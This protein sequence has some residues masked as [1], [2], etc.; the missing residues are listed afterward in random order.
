M[1][2]LLSVL[3]TSQRLTDIACRFR[4]TTWQATVSFALFGELHR[5]K[6]DFIRLNDQVRSLGVWLN[7]MCV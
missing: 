7:P 3:V 4:S 6:T 2:R 1:A 5:E